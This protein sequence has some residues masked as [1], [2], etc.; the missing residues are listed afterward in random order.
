MEIYWTPISSSDLELSSS[1][2][3]LTS[4]TIGKRFGRV[5]TRFNVFLVDLSFYTSKIIPSKIN[6]VYWE[7]SF[8][9]K[10]AAL[11]RNNW[12]LASFSLPWG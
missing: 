5:A 8:G 12:S 6:L 9:G 4:E 10:E 7:I 11:S 2:A 1:W 3:L